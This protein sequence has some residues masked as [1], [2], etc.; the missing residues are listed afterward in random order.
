MSPV[1]TGR[2]LTRYGHLPWLGAILLVGLALR[3][4]GLG[5]GLPNLQCRPDESTVVN[6]ALGIA[7]GDPNPHFFNYPTFHLYLL[8]FLDGLWY[9]A[10][11]ALGLFAGLADFE[12]LVLTDPSSLYL[13]ARSLTVAF[14]IASV[15]L[16]YLVGR[17]LDDELSG[18]LA[19]G[20][21]AVAFLHVRDSHFATVDVPAT[22]HLLVAWGLLLRYLDQGKRGALAGAAAFFGLAASTKYNLGLFAGAA[23]VAPWIVG[24]RSVRRS[25]VGSSVA[26]VVAGVAFVVGTPFALLDPSTFLRDL[27]FEQAHF[28]RGHAGLDLGPGWLRHLTF[29]LP[30]GLGWPLLAVALIG[31]ALLI[32]RRGRSGL[33]L[34]GSV[35]VYYG[36]AGSG[37]GVFMRYLVPL[38]PLLCVCAGVAVRAAL[39]GSRRRWPAVVLA[40]VVALPSATA[41][42]SCDRLLGETD[43][44][45]EAARWLEANV[46]AGAVIALVGSDYGQPQ[47]RRTREW[48]KQEYADQQAAGLPTRRL[49]RQLALDRSPPPPA[50][51]VVEVKPAGP[52][53]RAAVRPGC[54]LPCLSAAGVEW[55]VTQEHPLPYSRVEPGLAL[56]L[57]RQAVAVRVFDPFVAGAE[58]PVYDQVDAFYLPVT[59]F[60]GVTRPGPRLRIFRLPDAAASE[61]PILDRPTANG[62][63]SSGSDTRDSTRTATATDSTD[64]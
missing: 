56:Q 17:R 26:L 62:E 28:A 59:G 10:G 13:L 39:A 36:V 8:A 1:S 35:L 52:F 60:S 41:S 6:V 20:F 58:T 32:R 27:A 22:F 55:V 24:P 50:Y 23:L 29:T 33:L 12:R 47:V 9:L 61:A 18:L 38:V 34:A 15:G 4:W 49:A 16:V 14:G 30:H 37:R 3:I 46:P 11:R 5:F 40:V 2:V 48:L 31:W 53:R 43:T 44:R 64:I 51:E 45:V 25:F 54:D 63:L 42:W 57:E 19:A 7:A 21:L